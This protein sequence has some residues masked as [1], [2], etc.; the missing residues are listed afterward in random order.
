MENSQTKW[1]VHSLEDSMTEEKLE[2]K[3]QALDLNNK[4]NE[5][6]LR[7]KYNQAICQSQYNQALLKPLFDLPIWKFKLVEY[8]VT[9]VIEKMEPKD[10]WHFKLNQIHNHGFRPIHWAAW[11]GNLDIIKYM[12][13]KYKYYLMKAADPVDNEGRYPIHHTVIGKSNLE[14]IKYLMNA[15]HEKQPKDKYGKSPLDYAKE[16]GEDDIVAY[17]ESF[18][19]MKYKDYSKQALLLAAE[20]G[21]LELVKCLTRYFP[22]ADP[23]NADGYS[24]LHWAAKNGHL[25]VVKHLMT[26]VIKKEPIDNK[27][28]RPIHEAAKAGH[29]HIVRYLMSVVKEKQPKDNSGM[30]PIH[31][32]FDY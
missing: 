13:Y 27:G 8:L 6:C 22:G 21:N 1:L 7:A 5:F 25:E 3:Y 2:P 30:M 15:I 9:M 20:V 29:L 12:M 32:Y 14:T 16:R 28:Q 18:S 26:T 19:N 4:G 10:K 31:Y 23:R 11:T 24:P 17:L